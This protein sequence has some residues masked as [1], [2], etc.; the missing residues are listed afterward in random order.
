[1]V[2]IYV[3][4]AISWNVSSRRQEGGVSQKRHPHQDHPSSTVGCVRVRACACVCVC[5]SGRWHACWCDENTHVPTNSTLSSCYKA[6]F[7][8]K[9]CTAARK[10]AKESQDNALKLGAVLAAANKRQRCQR[11]QR[12]ARKLEAGDDTGSSKNNPQGLYFTRRETKLMV[13]LRFQE[14]GEEGN[15]DA[16]IFSTSLLK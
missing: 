3:C 15:I 2:S 12:Y 16:V 5:E 14:T 4:Q 7:R 6:L 1:M 10:L 9:V 13:T 8:S 11:C